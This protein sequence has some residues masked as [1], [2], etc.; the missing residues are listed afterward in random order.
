MAQPSQTNPPEVARDILEAQLRE[1]YGRV[2]YSHKTHEKCADMLLERL[3]RVKLAQIILSALT[4]AGFVAA[5]FGTG[6]I[7]S[8]I[9][10]VVSTLLLALNAY[11]KDYDLGEIAQKHRQAACDLWL[12][13]EMY[14]SLITDLRMGKRA[15]KEIEDDRD[16][17]LTRLHAVYGGAPN[18]TYPAYR[19]AQDALQKSEDMTFT[20]DEIDAFLPKSLKKSERYPPPRF[21]P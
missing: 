9:G 8:V 18:T 12:V 2:V 5:I 6:Q 1:C 20:D 7:G 17:L 3:S 10:L 14:L 15:L 11:T 4:T 16:K 19:K 13:R 21:T